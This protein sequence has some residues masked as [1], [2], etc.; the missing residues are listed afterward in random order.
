M[1]GFPGVSFVDAH[2]S[3]I[4]AALSRTTGA[5]GLVTLVS[6]GSAAVLLAYHDAYV[7]TTP[8]CQLTTAAALR[9][10]PP[11][12][13]ASLTVATS[14]MACANRQAAGTA[15]IGPVTTPGGIQP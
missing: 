7:A 1:Q 10:Y 2:G 12:Q 3:Q 8:N 11:G 15:G 6:G 5:A 13:T 14:L 4:G 9:I